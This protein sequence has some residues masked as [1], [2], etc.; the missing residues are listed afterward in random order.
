[1]LQSLT[2]GRVV[3]F[4]VLEIDAEPLVVVEE[5]VTERLQEAV[6]QS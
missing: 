3:I 2:K 5:S 6:T 1:M 4:D